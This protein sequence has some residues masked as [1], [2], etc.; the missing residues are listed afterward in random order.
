[1]RL[2]EMNKIAEFVNSPEHCRMSQYLLEYHLCGVPGCDICAGIGIEVKTPHIYFGGYNL[3]DEVLR[4]DEYPIV[5]SSNSEHYLSPE[6][7]RD[8]IKHNNMTFEKLKT[9]LPNPN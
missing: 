7:T 8:Y 9:V 1:M 4:W 2:K 5:G 6:V 3:R